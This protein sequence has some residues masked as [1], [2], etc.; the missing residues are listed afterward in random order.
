MPQLISYVRLLGGPNPANKKKIPVVI[1]CSGINLYPYVTF[2][3][4]ELFPGEQDEEAFACL[5]LF[6]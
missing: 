3:L 2:S 5:T 6:S 4:S 1:L